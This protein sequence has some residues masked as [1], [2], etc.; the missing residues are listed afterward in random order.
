MNK[1]NYSDLLTLLN[2]QIDN[3]S[4]SRYF[5]A[6]SGAPG[7]GKSTVSEKLVGD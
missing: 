5:I 3:H 7:S 4:T 6:R 2:K 1:L